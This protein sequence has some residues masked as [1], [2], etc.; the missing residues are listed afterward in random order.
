MKPY[1]DAGVI[2]GDQTYIGMQTRLRIVVRVPAPLGKP[3]ADLPGDFEP[4]LRQAVADA[5]V[6]L[7][8]SGLEVDYVA[9]EAFA[10]SEV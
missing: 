10:D 8:V 2:V 1:S 5:V 4:A 9:V 3:G 7:A 6:G